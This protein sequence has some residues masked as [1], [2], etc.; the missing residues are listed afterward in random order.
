ME[1]EQH[2][3]E[4]DRRILLGL[5]GDSQRFETCPGGLLLGAPEL[6]LDCLVEHLQTIEKV[7]RQASGS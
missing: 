5:E 2:D 3:H 6:F 4:N 1:A 7:E